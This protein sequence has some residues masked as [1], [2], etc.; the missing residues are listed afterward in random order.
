MLLGLVK[1]MLKKIFIKRQAFYFLVWVI[2]VLH[3][4]N[5]FFGLRKI[6]LLVLGA[7]I[8]NGCS[9]YRNVTFMNLRRNIIVGN[10]VTIN[11]NC[12]LDDRG[13]IQIGNNVNISQNVKI[14]TGGHN[15]YDPKMPFFSKN[16]LLDDN[17]WVFPNVIIMPG[18]HLKE[19]CIVLPGAVV[20]KSFDSFSIIGGNPAR[21]V[22]RRCKQIDYVIDFRYWF[23]M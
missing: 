20:S 10:N 14:Y 23:G 7:E 22:K 8:G 15:I 17:V 4:T 2:N 16:V 11:R 3:K 9:I 1:E 19:G 21:F 13:T 6:L 12:L 18:V 5:P